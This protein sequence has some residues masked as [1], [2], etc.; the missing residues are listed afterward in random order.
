MENPMSGGELL[1]AA[2]TGTLGFVASD[3]L[4]RWLAAKELSTGGSSLAT[5][6][7]GLTPGMASLTKPGIM[8]ILAQLGAAAVPFA[9]AYWVKEPMG[10]AA[11]QGAGLGMIFHLGGQLFQHY[12]I[13]KWVGGSAPAA[14][15][16]AATINGYYT[17]ELTADNLSDQATT[18]TAGTLIAASTG[19][20]ATGAISGVLR[21]VGAAHLAPRALAAPATGKVGACG[22]C[23]GGGG[24]TAA[25]FP[26]DNGGDGDCV[27]PVAIPPTS[28]QPQQPLSP[29]GGGNGASP[30]P[31]MN[32][33]GNG[34]YVPPTSQP[35][36]ALQG[37]G[38][39]GLNQMFP[40]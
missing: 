32:G 31:P 12:V 24:L 4:D 33:G 27:T 17:P 36:G 11:L 7:T 16:L 5:G 40:D 28:S 10:R 2:A 30:L 38:S 29:Y 1:L 8:R 9:G 39:I 20:A 14:G 35:G 13:A 23:A 26:N 15:S 3:L 22:P 25:A 6:Q 34:V 21:G 19:T 37:L 18:G